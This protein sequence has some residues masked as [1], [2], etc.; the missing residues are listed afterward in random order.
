VK[1]RA[2]GDE[3]TPEDLD[4]IEQEQPLIEAELALLNAEIRILTAK[5]GP[6]P[7]DWQRLW[8]TERRVWREALLFI[9]QRHTASRRRMERAA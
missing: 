1:A 6:S 3:P 7:L 8:H 5:G 9:A 2:M 4:L